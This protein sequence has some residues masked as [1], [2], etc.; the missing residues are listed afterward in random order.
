MVCYVVPAI[1]AVVQYAARKNILSLKASIHQLWLSFLLIGG[2]VF[3]IVDHLWNGE[4][5]FIG[6]N[7]SS[8]LLLGVM[9]TASILMVWGF[10]VFLDNRTIET[11]K[12][13]V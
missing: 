2:T 6:P 3:G 10:I 4:L 1:A 8:D 7:I 11:Y 9:I 13:S 12:K 5:F